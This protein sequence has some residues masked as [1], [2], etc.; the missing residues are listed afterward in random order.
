MTMRRIAVLAAV[1]SSQ[2]NDS[3]GANYGGYY[4]PSYN[5]SGNASGKS[6]RFDTDLHGNVNVLLGGAMLSGVIIVVI[7]VCYCCHKNIRKNRPH[8]YSPYWREPDVQSLEVFTMDSHT[9][10]R[11]LGAQ[12]CYDRSANTEEITTMSLSCPGTP[13]PPPTYESLI[14][15]SHHNAASPS[16]K[17][18]EPISTGDCILP[19]CGNQGDSQDQEKKGDD[20]GLPS[21][22]AA[23]KLEANGYV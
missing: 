21:Y 13:G 5:M 1:H 19:V 12:Q 18:E 16:D 6:G 22:E 20:E 14:F 17:K 23:L 8:E 9:M 11:F 2:R 15:N 7:L 10:G 3:N 4:S